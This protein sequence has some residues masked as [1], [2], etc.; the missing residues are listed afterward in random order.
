MAIPEGLKSA[1]RSRF[2]KAWNRMRVMNKGVRLAPRLFGYHPRACNI[3][4]FEGK[5][6]A[7]IHFPDIF[8]YDAV[9]PQCGSQPRHRLLMLA[10]AG[11]RLVGPE[12][13]MVHFAPERCITGKLRALA[14]EYIT[15]DLDPRGVDR[16]ENIEALSF[17]D[18]SLD[19]VF[20]SHVLE[21]VDHHEALAE[22]Y[23]VLVPG[24]RLLAFFPIVEGWEADYEN[25]E[26]YD[27]RLRGIHFGKDNHL[28]RFGRNV[29]QAFRDAG[30]ALEDYTAEGQTSV[31]H[32]LIPGEVLFVATRPAG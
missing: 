29:R 18:E 7:E 32:G 16:Q 1:L 22:L 6:L 31:R 19:V 11:R 3:C 23:R 20:C 2:P 27:G 14:R 17:A 26:V 12:D 10:I 24:G 25:P 9:C 13:R 5:F 15:A 21:H 8:V 28:R 30:F 4:G